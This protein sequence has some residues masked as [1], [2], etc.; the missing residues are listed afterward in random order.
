MSELDVTAL[1]SIPVKEQR[2]VLR[3]LRDET[4]GGLLLVGVALTALAWANSPWANSYERLVD[5]PI[6]TPGFMLPF[7]IWA[8]DFLLAIFFFVVGIELKH[9]FV[10][11]TLSSPRRAVVPVAAALGGMLSSAAIFLALNAGS[12]Q[13][14]AWGIPVSTDI[15]FALAVLAIFGKRLPIELRSLLLTLAVVNDLGAITVIA[16][17]YGHGFEATYF[18]IACV[19]VALFAVL[20]N[21]GINSLAVYL[22]LALVT[23][24]F[25][26]ESGIHAT[27]AGVA[28]GLSMRVQAR[29]GEKESPGDRVEHALRPVSAG[30]CVPLF[31]LVAAGVSLA[32]ISIGAATREPLAL[33]I[34]LGLVVGQ[35]VGVTLFAF[36]ATKLSGGTL[37]PQLTWWDVA[38]VG[39]LASIGFTVA[40][41]VSEVSFEHNPSMLTVAK[42]A[43]VATNACAIGLSVLAIGVRTRFIGRYQL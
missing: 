18:L 30:I 9:E 27:V 19:L 32:G 1:E 12:P 41:L 14:S 4:T 3:A 37:N 11:G 10:S 13:Q 25:M 16:I 42:F 38:V 8:A 36:V 26:Y 35:P 33:G 22:P 34:L 6:G 15:A 40:L 5:L 21:R 17:F 43:I 29:D 28:L 2:W 31:A 20:Q 39:T 24:Y 23:W 7:R